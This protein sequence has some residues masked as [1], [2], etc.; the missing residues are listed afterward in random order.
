MYFAWRWLS[1]IRE[2]FEIKV[3]HVVSSLVV[4]CSFKFRIIVFL[5]TFHN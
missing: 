5:V 2:R 3:Y 1:L 4:L